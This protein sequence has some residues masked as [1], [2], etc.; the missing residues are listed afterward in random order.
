MKAILIAKRSLL[1]IA[2]CALVGKLPLS[3]P[4]QSVTLFSSIK[5]Q[6]QQRKN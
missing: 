5:Y 1:G 4:G 2:V 3:A 6:G